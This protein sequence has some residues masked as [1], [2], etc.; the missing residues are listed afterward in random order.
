MRDAAARLAPALRGTTART[1]KHHWTRGTASPRPEAGRRDSSRAGIG[2]GPDTAHRAGRCTQRDG[3]PDRAVG[4]W[5]IDLA[6]RHCRSVAAAVGHASRWRAAPLVTCPRQ[7]CAPRWAYLPQVS[8]LVSGT[9]RSNLRLAA[10]DATDD[11]DA[12]ASDRPR[13]LAALPLARG[14]DMS[15]RRRGHGPVGGRGAARRA[16]PRDPAPPR[17]P[18]A[19]RADRGAGPGQRGP[20]AGCDPGAS[21]RRPPILHD[22]APRHRPLGLRQKADTKK[23]ILNISF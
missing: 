2:G 12:G 8:R 9:I 3:R 7:P 4:P 14:L 16:G 18:A 17:D 19:R 22:D 10:P 6:Q 1:G 11:H 21:A 5:Q 15:A 23:H 13:P 20:G